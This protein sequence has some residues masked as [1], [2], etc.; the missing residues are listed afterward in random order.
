MGL[1]LP[2]RRAA[3]HDRLLVSEFVNYPAGG[4]LV[5]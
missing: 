5:E 4:P 3:T 2:D 1:S